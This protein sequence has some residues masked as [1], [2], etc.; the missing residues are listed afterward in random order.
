MSDWIIDELRSKRKAYVQLAKDSTGL[1]T[2]KSKEE[3]LEH[4]YDIDQTIAL[5]KIVK[6]SMDNFKKGL[7]GPKLDLEDLKPI[8]ED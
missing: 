1:I 3:A 7:V 6:Q 8:F 2:E 4:I 5:L